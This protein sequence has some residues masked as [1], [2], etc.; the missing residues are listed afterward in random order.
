MDFLTSKINAPFQVVVLLPMKG[1]SERVPN[2]NMKS[3]AG[4]PLYHII[5]RTLLQ[6]DF[7]KKIII[8]TVSEEIASDA[9]KNFEKIEIHWRPAHIQGDFV[10]M[11]EIIV[12]GLSRLEGE[13]FLQTHSTNPLIQAETIDRAIESYFLHLD[14]YDSLFSVTR[15][16]TRLYW[17]DCKPV[18]H[19]LTELL[20][21]Q[22]L[23]AI[24]EENSNFYIFSKESFYRAGNNRIG[25]RP[26]M[27]EVDKLEA[28]DIDEPQD[29]ELAEI[30]YKVRWGI[31][32]S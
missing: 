12:Y 19:D 16:Q 5:V 14:T 13:H 11:N 7:V 27:F 4:V 6:S 30:L 25:L 10:S 28:I 15:L 21:T 29:F 3:I 24:F 2:K 1:R 18:N 22:D 20:R 32:E 17:E 9:L 31:N 23:P 8:N 26:Q